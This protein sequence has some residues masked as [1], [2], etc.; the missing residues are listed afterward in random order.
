MGKEKKEII[1]YDD[2]KPLNEQEAAEFLGVPQGTLKAWR[3]R[4]QGP[5]YSK[6]GRH[7][8]YSKK[9]LIEFLEEKAVV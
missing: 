2:E 6:F 4:G 3:Y 7:I 8:R 1:E 5:V 9:Y